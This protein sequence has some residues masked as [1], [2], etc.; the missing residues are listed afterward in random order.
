MLYPDDPSHGFAIQALKGTAYSVVGILH[1]RDINVDGTV[2]KPHYHFVVKFANARSL[3]VVANELQIETRF[4]EACHSFK[5]SAAYL[6]HRGCPDK[7]QY[8]LNDVFGSLKKQLEQQLSDDTEDDRAMKIVGLL[9]GV[10]KPITMRDFIF[11][12][13]ENGLF[14]D[15]RRGGYLFV[16][17]LKE[18][19]EK[20]Y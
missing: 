18:H 5:N 19:N 13:A 3:T 11:I 17:A 15:L 9:D 4:L 7:F 12:C 6:L 8:S 20:Y 16:Q 1:D 14:S 2:K 10:D